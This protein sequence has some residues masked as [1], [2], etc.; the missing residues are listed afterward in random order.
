M[1][2][3]GCGETDGDKEMQNEKEERQRAE[4]MEG[5]GTDKQTTRRRESATEESGEKEEWSGGRVPPAILLHWV[6]SKG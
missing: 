4:G 2:E 6:A 3:T 5:G 1:D